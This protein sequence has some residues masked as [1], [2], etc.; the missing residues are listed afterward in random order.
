MSSTPGL[1]PETTYPDG[2]T[3]IQTPSQGARARAAG[4]LLVGL[5]LVIV[6]ILM[7]IAR[8]KLHFLYDNSISSHGDELLEALGVLMD[9]ERLFT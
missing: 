7:A 5:L 4:S 3:E 2:R 8:V 9:E 6:P 1:L